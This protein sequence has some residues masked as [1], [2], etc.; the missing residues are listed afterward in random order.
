MNLMGCYLELL[1]KYL[2][3]RL[4]ITIEGETDGANH[5]RNH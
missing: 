2:K 4:E 3:L 5:H 1:V